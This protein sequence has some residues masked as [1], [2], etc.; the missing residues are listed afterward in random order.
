MFVAKNRL[1]RTYFV[2]NRGRD[3]FNVYYSVSFPK[4]KRKSLLTLKID[5]KRMD[6]SGRQVLMLKKILSRANQLTTGRR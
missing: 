2:G 1:R 6:L 5:N 3:G 4:A